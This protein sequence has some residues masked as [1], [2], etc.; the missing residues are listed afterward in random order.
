MLPKLTY[1]D[2]MEVGTAENDDIE[3]LLQVV[4]IY[5]V[6]KLF[7]NV[8]RKKF[9]LEPVRA[10]DLHGDASDKATVFRGRYSIVYQR[11]CNHDL[12]RKPV[13]GNIDEDNKK[14]GLI[15]RINFF[16]W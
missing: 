5:K 12:F 14:F 9:V 10:Q 3:N 13:I 1:L 6:P 2:Y 8:E 16:N 4:D 15:K 7:Y 11:T